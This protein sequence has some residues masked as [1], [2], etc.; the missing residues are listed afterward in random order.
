MDIR[1]RG[2]RDG[3]QRV[4]EE[5]IKR[6]Q[7]VVDARITVVKNQMEENKERVQKKIRGIKD[8]L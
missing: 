8:R 7:Q 6:E 3:V 4:L 2:V 1:I 5:R